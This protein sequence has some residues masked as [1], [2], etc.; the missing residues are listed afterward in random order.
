MH[1]NETQSS[2]FEFVTMLYNDFVCINYLIIL[3]YC[4]FILCY[5][6]GSN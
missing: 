2:D 3:V 1:F 6:V 5:L 4:N